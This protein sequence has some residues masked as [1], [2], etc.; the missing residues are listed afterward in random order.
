MPTNANIKPITTITDAPTV[1]PTVTAILPDK[2]DG[3]A[4]A[5]SG[6]NVNILD[7]R[8]YCN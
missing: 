8:A 7:N 3:Y 2:E 1:P 5:G 6:G 4:I